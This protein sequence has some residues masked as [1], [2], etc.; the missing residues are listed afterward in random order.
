MPD[1]KNILN[2][3]EKNIEFLFIVGLKLLGTRFVYFFII[4]FF[5]SNM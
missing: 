5:Y 3:L 4:S 1:K 2:T